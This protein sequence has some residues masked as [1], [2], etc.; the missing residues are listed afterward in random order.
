MIDSHRQAIANALERAEAHAPFLANLIAREADLVADI[1]AN[2]P[3]IAA[4]LAP[5]EDSNVARDLRVRRRR[6]ALA[7]AVGDLAGVLDF[8]SVTHALSDFADDALDTAICTA[9][10]ERYPDAEPR[11]FAAIALG[12]HGSRELNYSSDIDPVFLFDP[13]TLPRRAKEEPVEAAVRIGKRVV[14]LLQARDGD[15]YVLRVDLRLRPSP[16]ATP[17]MNRR[18]CRGSAPPSSDHAWRRGT[19]RWVRS[20]SRPCSPLSGAAR[21]IS[22]RSARFAAYRAES[23]RITRRGR[24]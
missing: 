5:G 20:F 9:I 18:R 16:E 24:R 10:T 12:K 17:I 2:G 13:E 19:G 4:L 1:A 22:A 7:L 6:L 14:E 21:S 8:E 3:D 15:G 11:G 23:A